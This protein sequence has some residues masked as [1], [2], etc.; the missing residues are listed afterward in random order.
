MAR[1]HEALGRLAEKMI[2]R[3][4]NISREE[5][6]IGYYIMWASFTLCMVENAEPYKEQFLEILNFS[7]QVLQKKDLYHKVIL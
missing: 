2:L 6:D 3:Y 1:M 7:L 5:Q 4:Q